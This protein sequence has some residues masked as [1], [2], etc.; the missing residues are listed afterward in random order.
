LEG[1]DSFLA[2]KIHRR[3]VSRNISAL[4][5]VACVVSLL[6]FTGSA[7]AAFPG[8]NGKIATAVYSVVGHLPGDPNI[9]TVNP[10]GGG[11]TRL[12]TDFR[13]SGPSWSPNGSRIAFNSAR[14]GNSEVYTMNADGSDLTQITTNPAGDGSPAWSPDGS[15]IA[16][17]SN[18]TGN[19]DLYVMNADGTGV[20][21]LTTSTGSDGAPAW[22]PD[23]SE[24]AFSRYTP[25]LACCDYTQVIY[26]IAIDGT[27][28]RQIV[29]HPAANPNWSP[30]GSR[31][32][33]NS[34]GDAWTVNAD[35]TGPRQLTSESSPNPEYIFLSNSNPAWSPDGSKIAFAHSECG[36]GSCGGPGLETV[37]PDGTGRVALSQGGEPDWQPLVG[38]QRADYKNAAQYCKALRDFLGDEA[39]RNRYGGGANAHGKC[40]SG[41]GR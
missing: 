13:S 12:T 9:F 22:S 41:D 31:I 21:Q 40:V 15:K 25:G 39:F 4:S 27:G 7:Q 32:A 11:L 14:S 23:G 18:R 20:T 34:G 10:D 6:V 26:A 2:F 8:K 28:E 30:D 16:F 24:I 38:P 5:A 36:I 17:S 29:G 1:E 19:G 37:N 3:A 35:G 33:Y